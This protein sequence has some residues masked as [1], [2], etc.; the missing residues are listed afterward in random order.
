[1]S[2]IDNILIENQTI[3]QGILQMVSKS[4]CMFSLMMMGQTLMRMLSPIRGGEYDT[5][6]QIPY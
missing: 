5:L 2:K 6:R 3:R 1:M 4:F